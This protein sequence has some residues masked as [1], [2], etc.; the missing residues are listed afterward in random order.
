M[1]MKQRTID[2]IVCFNMLF[3]QNG[4]SGSKYGQSVASPDLLL[5]A[6]HL[7]TEFRAMFPGI[8]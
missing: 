5:P 3:R 7:I 4:F 1:G 2:F 8:M 6:L